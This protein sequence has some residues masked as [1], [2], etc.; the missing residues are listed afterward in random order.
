MYD[1]AEVETDIN[2]LDGDIC[3]RTSLCGH[4]VPSVEDMM[5]TQGLY[6]LVEDV[7]GG[8]VLGKQS[9]SGTFPSRTSST[10]T[11]SAGISCPHRDVLNGD[12]LDG[13]MYVHFYFC[14]FV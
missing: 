13:D 12:V 1:G 8:D 6:V 7:L 4:D 14:P 11:S 2:V 3:P 5:S 9:S 10:G